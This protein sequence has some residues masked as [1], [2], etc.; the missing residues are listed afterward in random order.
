[1]LWV[2]P[3]PWSMWCAPTACSSLALGLNLGQWGVGECDT[4]EDSRVSWPWP[5]TLLSSITMKR[6]CPEHLTSLWETEEHVEQSQSTN[7]SK[8]GQNTDTN[9]TQ[10]KPCQA[11]PPQSHLHR[12]ARRKHLCFH[13]IE[14]LG[15]LLHDMRSA[16]DTHMNASWFL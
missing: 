8:L 3:S 13:A 5:L 14:F 1:M 2:F 12:W 6:T 7:M 9:M 10:A 15:V 11:H 16:A 4:R